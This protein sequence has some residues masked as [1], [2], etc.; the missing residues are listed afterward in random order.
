M[1]EPKY[2]TYNVAKLL[3][4]KGFDLPCIYFWFEKGNISKP[5][6]KQ[7]Q[8]PFNWNNFESGMRRS[9]PL[10]SDVVDW[11]LEKHGIWVYVNEEFRSHIIRD[12]ENLIY[13]GQLSR[14]APYKG[15]FIT[16]YSWD[17]PKEAYEKA[18]E[19]ILTN[20]I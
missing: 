7:F 4:E 16:K 11:L 17:T 19:Y 10:Q 12:K 2:V 13:G 14:L 20:L 15:G 6:R 5:S 1:S 9:A 18:F 8:I 3:K